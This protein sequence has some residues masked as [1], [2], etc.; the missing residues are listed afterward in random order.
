MV[1]GRSENAQVVSGGDGA[2]ELNGRVSEGGRVAG[3][4]SLLDIVSS[5]TTDDE[6]LMCDNTVNSCVH[7]SARWVVVE[8]GTGVEGALLEIEG[9]LLRL[10]SLL[11]GESAEELS[12][13]TSGDCVFKLKLGVD[14]VLGRPCL[15]DGDSYSVQIS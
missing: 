10:W 7:I 3:Q 11:G 14:Q 2:G 4:S 13:E 9:E 6:S 8:E 15:G 12:L 5:L 1:V